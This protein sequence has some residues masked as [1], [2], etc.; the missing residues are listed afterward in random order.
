MV[1]TR[2]VDVNGLGWDVEKTCT[3]IEQTLNQFPQ[4]EETPQIFSRWLNLVKT[5]QI[6]G[7]RVHDA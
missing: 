7:K 1:A 3:E 6:K 5:Y 4:L 2:P